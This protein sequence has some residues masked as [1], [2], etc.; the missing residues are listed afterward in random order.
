MPRQTE[1]KYLYKKKRHLNHVLYKLHL[2]GAE[3]NKVTRQHALI[4]IDDTLKKFM[5]INHRYLQNIINNLNKQKK[6]KWHINKTNHLTTTRKRN[7]EL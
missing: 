6:N 1:E 4:Q 3:F 7:P 2:Q 5:Q